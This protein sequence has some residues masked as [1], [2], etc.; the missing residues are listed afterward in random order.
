MGARISA[1]TESLISN[2]ELLRQSILTKESQVP[3]N[4]TFLQLKK[5]IDNIDSNIQNRFSYL[6]YYSE[7][8]NEFTLNFGTFTKTNI[9]IYNEISVFKDTINED[10]IYIV[11][12][13]NNDDVYN[14]NNG[15][16]QTKK[17]FIYRYFL[18]LRSFTLIYNDTITYT[19]NT[20]E[21]IHSFWVFNKDKKPYLCLLPSQ[22]Y[23]GATYKFDID[24]LTFNKIGNLLSC[25]YKGSIYEGIRGYYTTN[26]FV[27]TNKNGSSS[28][29]Y[30]MGQYSFDTNTSTQL[31]ANQKDSDINRY[32]FGLSS[33]C[34]N[35]LYETENYLIFP[36]DGYGKVNDLCL[37][38]KNTLTKTS[39]TNSNI[40]NFELQNNYNSLND[41]SYFE[42]YQMA[43]SVNKFS[44][45]ILYLINRANY[46]IIKVCFDSNQNI[47]TSANYF[48]FLYTGGLGILYKQLDETPLLFSILKNM[49]NIWPSSGNIPVSVSLLTKDIWKI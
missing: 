17:I 22:N 33:F 25:N 47:V 18:S 4:P 43:T 2:K 49:Q 3:K 31:K 19:P 27:F 28:S 12:A 30:R 13:V 23:S 37:W 34:Y 42:L 16:N 26:G 29:S 20:T 24:T 10:Y 35:I 46:C 38:N 44:E 32:C 5:G 15:W 45:N 1:I 6:N 41:Y 11:A 40:Y 39:I 21:Y 48:P 36:N 9:G 14:Y 8:T 7:N